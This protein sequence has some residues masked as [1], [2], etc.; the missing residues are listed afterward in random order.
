M[1]QTIILK[2]Q[3]HNFP[4][5]TAGGNMT[6]QTTNPASGTITYTLAA[7]APAVAA[8]PGGSVFTMVLPVNGNTLTVINNTTSGLSCVY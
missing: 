8:L 2:G 4:A 3:Q 7:N 6:L 5:G 1:P